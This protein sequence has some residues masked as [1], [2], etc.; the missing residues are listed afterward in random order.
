MSGVP[1]RRRV[2]CVCFCAI[3]HADFDSTKLNCGAFT[4][5]A[6]VMLQYCIMSHSA[7]TLCFVIF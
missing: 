4:E 5:T 2:Y 6:P 3:C 7:E 1:F